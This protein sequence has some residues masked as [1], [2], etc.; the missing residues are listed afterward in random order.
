MT[1]K[2]LM[3]KATLTKSVKVF[4]TRFKKTI[5]VELK[6]ILK[7]QRKTLDIFVQYSFSSLRIVKKKADDLKH[8]GNFSVF[9]SP[10]KFSYTS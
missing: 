3:I 1:L 10:S 6:G 9:D 5:L 8:Y 7:K 4:G 2:I